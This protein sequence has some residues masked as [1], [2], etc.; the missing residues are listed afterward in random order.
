MFTKQK[1]IECIL[2]TDG[3]TRDITFTP[4]SHFYMVEAIKN[5][6]EGYRIDN[7]TDNEGE[8]VSR[9]LK[10]NPAKILSEGNGYIHCVLVSDQQLIPC[11]QLF[12]D[13]D[14]QKKDEYCLEISFFPNDINPASFKL[15]DFMKLIDKWASIL[16]AKDYFV[17]YENAS[18]DLYDPKGFGVIYT[19]QNRP[20]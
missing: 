20:T 13:W 6:T 1:V 16:N 9:L 7:A 10:E 14:S 5:F 8:D 11:I 3:M 2:D 18:W 17:H 4:T 15:H 12:I 19:K